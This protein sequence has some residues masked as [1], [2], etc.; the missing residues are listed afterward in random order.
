MRHTIASTLR[1][2]TRTLLLAAAACLLGAATA[3]ADIT[4]ARRGNLETQ[5]IITGKFP[6]TDYRI[7]H[8]NL[9]SGGGGYTRT[10]HIIR[11]G[12][13][14]GSPTGSGSITIRHSDS[15]P[16]R[17]GHHLQLGDA[18]N[19]NAPNDQHPSG[20]PIE[21]PAPDPRSPVV[22]GANPPEPIVLRQA[23]QAPG[24][25]VIETWD[26]GTVYQLVLD[27]AEASWIN[28]GCAVSGTGDLQVQLLQCTAQ[29]IVFQIMSEPTM[30]PPN[31][32]VITGVGVQVQGQPCGPGVGLRLGFTGTSSVF[33]N[34]QFQT[35]IVGNGVFDL[36]RLPVSGPADVGRQG[37][38]AGRDGRY[39]NNDF[40][41]FIDMF[42][43]ENPG[44][45]RGAQGG[46]PGMD[47]QFDNNDFI[48]FIDQFFAG[49]NC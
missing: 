36:T 42:F 3:H 43:A 20:V 37:G 15:E 7:Y 25:M 34:G 5:V 16:V 49:A 48:V 26:P 28:A 6:N 27:P 1:S 14:N 41:A 40:I 2:P 18:N 23:M 12:P 31:D 32:V 39:D 30:F 47:G 22:P 35:Q 21:F 33:L 17:A 9:P 29:N 4:F 11:T 44:A 19:P 45:D 24:V 38:V 13:D 8:S 46:V 10:G